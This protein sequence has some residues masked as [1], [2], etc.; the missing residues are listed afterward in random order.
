MFSIFITVIK[1]CTMYSL[2]P[3]THEEQYVVDVIFRIVFILGNKLSVCNK[4]E[5]LPVKV[6]ER[7]VRSGIHS[8]LQLTSEAVFKEE[9]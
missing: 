9:P 5:Q 2:H 1:L 8:F 6:T 7:T 3:E 4:F